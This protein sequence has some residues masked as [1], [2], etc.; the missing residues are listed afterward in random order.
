MSPLLETISIAA[1]AWEIC[2]LHE[3]LVGGPDEA[4]QPWDLINATTRGHARASVELFLSDPTKMPE[5]WHKMNVEACLEAGWKWG[6]FF[7]DE[8]KEDPLLTEWEALPQSVR[9]IQTMFWHSAMA[10]AMETGHISLEDIQRMNELHGEE[11]ATREVHELAQAIIT[12][13][14][15]DE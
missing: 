2:R 1:L 3:A 11:Q 5:D 4:R 9:N 14:K 8:A 15:T 13:G 12:E 6:Y 7:H 10:I